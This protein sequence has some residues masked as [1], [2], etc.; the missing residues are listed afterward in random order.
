MLEKLEKLW[1][2]TIPLK[3][4]VRS[5]NVMVIIKSTRVSWT[6]KKYFFEHWAEDE[7]DERITEVKERI[8]KKKEIKKKIKEKRK[9]SKTLSVSD[10]KK[11]AVDAFQAWCR[12]RCAMR[13]N[14][15][16][17]RWY[18]ITTGKK[19]ATNGRSYTYYKEDYPDLCYWSWGHWVNRKVQSVLLD[20]QNCHLQSSNAN[21]E[22]LASFPV[23]YQ[24]KIVEMYW[25]ET[26]DRLKQAKLDRKNIGKNKPYKPREYK[27]KYEHYKKQLED[28]WVYET[29]SGYFPKEYLNWDKVIPWITT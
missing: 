13:D 22:Q 5:K 24:N 3:I 23:E 4:E 7:V 17:H 28:M 1:R 15:S 19:C 27:E 12:Y 8:K 21:R 6:K 29:K 25:Q 2:Y 16:I 14:N 9:K 11:K 18:C 26:L 10:Y 20:E